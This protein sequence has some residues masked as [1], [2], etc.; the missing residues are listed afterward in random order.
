MKIAFDENVPIAMVR[1]FQTFAN[2]R[3][4]QKLIS[5]KFEVESAKDYSPTKDDPDYVPHSDVP[6][7]KRFAA[8][9]GK[10]IISDNTDMKRQP[11]ER[12]ALIECGMIV[13][14]FESQ[15]SGWKF[16]RKCALLLHWWPEIAMKLKRAKPGSLAHPLQLP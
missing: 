10:A 4:L 14:F 2:E 6:W 1:V 16:F 7:V 3:Q 15:W 12:L 11:H 9:G 5:G 13:I 8:A